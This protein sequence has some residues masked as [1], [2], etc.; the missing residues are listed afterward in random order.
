MKREKN[1]DN[2]QILIDDVDIKKF[3]L[4][5]LHSQIGYVPQEPS[6]F[7]G[8]IRDNLIYGLSEVDENVDCKDN[9]KY[10]KEIKW[11]L[12]ISQA[13]FVFDESKFPLG[14]DTIVGSKGTKLSGGQK[15]RIAIARALIKR[16]KILIQEVFFSKNIYMII[17]IIR[18]LSMILKLFL[19]LMKAS[20]VM[21]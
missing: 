3:N 13:N 4:K 8:T 7:D 9:N 12:D 14:L 19:L 6:L 15:Q 17:L 11:S 5:C 2:C 10:E 18:T 1:D 21:N 20:L 16:P